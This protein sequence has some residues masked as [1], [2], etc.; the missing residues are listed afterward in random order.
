MAHSY[1]VHSAFARK[2]LA[3]QEE[4]GQHAT[5]NHAKRALATSGSPDNNLADTTD[6]PTSNKRESATRILETTIVRPA[7]PTRASHVAPN[8]K[9]RLGAD[10]RSGAPKR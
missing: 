2:P 3:S 5:N 1:E 8:M 9:G 10:T 6:K 4:W 7:L